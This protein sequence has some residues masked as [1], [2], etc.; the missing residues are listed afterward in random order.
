[1][2][3]FSDFKKY[4]DEFGLTG[5]NT[6]GTKGFSTQNGALFTLEY[7]LC[8]LNDPTTSKRDKENELHRLKQVYLMLEKFPGVSARKPGDSEFDSM[9][10]AGA[11]LTFSA[12]FDDS[13]YAERS[14]DHGNDVMC[15]GIDETQDVGNNKKWYWLADALNLWRGPKWFWNCSNPNKFCFNGWHGRSPGFKAYLKMTS[16]RFVGPWGQFCI[17]VGQFL[18]CFKKTTDTDARKLPY[19]NWQYLKKRNFIW[20]LFYK[21][22]CKI[23]MWQYPNGMRDVYSIYFKD[24]NHPLRI[25]SKPFEP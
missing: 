11:M 5:L 15:D 21:L 23:L 13:N 17:L 1:M 22:W 7:L 9:D 16:N 3:L 18:G 8:L 4:R 14:Y 12:L 6:D 2:S 20:N 24:P 25:Y 10:N 19:C